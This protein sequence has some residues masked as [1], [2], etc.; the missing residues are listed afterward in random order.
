MDKIDDAIIDSLTKDGRMSFRRIARELGIS[1]D[2]VI[3][4]YNKLKKGGLLMD[5]TIVIDLK[6]IGYTG[7]V[8]FIIN[9]MPSEDS[10]SFL[11]KIVKIPN[12]I[13]ATRTVGESNIFAVAAVRGIK[14]ILRV[15]TQIARIPGYNKKQILITEC[16]KQFPMGMFSRMAHEH[17]K[18][19][20]LK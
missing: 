8:A 1:P 2:R 10:K 18:L 16:P 4:R 17:T 9:I 20:K 13:V 3:N 14:D 7:M 11:S 12:V 19:E 15:G 5:P 6:K